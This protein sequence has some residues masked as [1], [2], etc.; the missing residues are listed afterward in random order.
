MPIEIR[1]LTANDRAVWEP[2]WLGYQNFYEVVIPPEVSDVTFGRLLDPAEP[3]W[4]ALAWDTDG[5]N[6]EE[7]VGHVHYIRHRTCWTAADTCYLQDL[8]VA[9]NRRAKGIGRKLIGHVYDAASKMGCSRVYWLTHETNTDAMKLYD[10]V[11]DKPGFVQYRRAMP[12][13]L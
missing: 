5:P 12:A 9:P 6:G 10:Q 2:L 1:P 4:C 3:M 8:F 13:S 7:A 11:A